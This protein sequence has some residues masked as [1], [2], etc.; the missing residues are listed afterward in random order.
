MSRIYSFNNVSH[1][2]LT[3]ISASGGLSSPIAQQI[4]A[5]E[6]F[7]QVKEKKIRRTNWKSGSYFIPKLLDTISNKVIGTDY[8][9]GEPPRKHFTWSIKEGFALS[10]DG[11]TWEFYDKDRGCVS[12]QSVNTKCVCE[13]PRLLSLGCDCGAFQAEMKS[14]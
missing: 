2:S 9:P 4:N 10:K 3:R 6:F 5:E 13:T 14:K 1:H 11:T 7:E 8:Y 12:S